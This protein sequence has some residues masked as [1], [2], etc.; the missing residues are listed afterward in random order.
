[1]ARI[2]EPEH[3]RVGDVVRLHANTR[4]RG[5]PQVRTVAITRLPHGTTIPLQAVEVAK[6]DERGGWKPHNS[7]G[8]NMIFDL[9][10]SARY[11][12]HDHFDTAFPDLPDFYK[13]AI[14]FGTF[15]CR[16]KGH[17]LSGDMD[18]REITIPKPELRLSVSLTGKVKV[19]VFCYSTFYDVG[20]CNLVAYHAG[21]EIPI[22][23]DKFAAM[24]K[25]K[26]ERKAARQAQKKTR[27]A[28]KPK[29]KIAGADIPHRIRT[30]ATNTA[31]ICGSLVDQL[32]L[33]LRMHVREGGDH[34]GNGCLF[35]LGGKGGAKAFDAY[36]DLVFVKPRRP[37][38]EAP[39]ETLKVA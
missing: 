21:A 28:R 9:P 18:Q 23:G 30:L 5:R 7:H 14:K 29:A 27:G 4:L 32:P 3:L 1:M 39:V 33:D 15:G 17:R 37:Q 20:R 8:K 36:L 31:S 10:Q 16:M 24:L 6:D 12:L 2:L 38:A 11:I 26:R 19:E 13:D 35:F 25:N 34:R 22:I